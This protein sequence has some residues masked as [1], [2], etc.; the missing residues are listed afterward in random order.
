VDSGGRFY[1]DWAA[2]AP[3]FSCPPGTESPGHAALFGNPSSG[4]LEGRAARS[5]LEEARRVCA[6]ALGAEAGT[7][8]F[9]SGATEANAIVLF[10]LLCAQAGGVWQALITT[11]AEHPS[12]TNNCASLG[13]MGIPVHYMGV[14]GYGGAVPAALDKALHKH[15]GAT[16]L[17]L[18]YVNNETG[19]ISDLRG[20][21]ETAR[22]RD[23][24]ALHIHSDMAQALGKIP[25]TLSDM[26][27]DSAVFS[28]HK[29]GGPRGIGILYLRK[30]VQTLFKGGGQERGIRPG[31]E[32]TAGALYFAEALRRRTAA[33]AKDREEAVKKM[34]R[35]VE[36][37]RTVKRCTIIPECREAVDGR[38]SPYILQAAFKGVP[39]EVMTRALDD[40]GFAVSTGSACST[41]S[42]KRP[43]LNALG[44]D[45][46]V[47]FTSIRISFGWNTQTGDIDALVGA[48]RS[49]LS[50]L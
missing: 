8:Y 33:A 4:H 7:L 49:V 18:M 15:P 32:N 50:K 16:M 36:S 25:F 24:K 3:P 40:L 48:V 30:P 43:V 45:D 27:V 5:A 20:L 35:L 10:S 6:E 12:I 39:G 22:R 37:L 47:A 9:T 14:D 28:A 42:K 1:F 17:A 29:V 21:A 31:T 44:V 26:D 23:G 13:H 19:A 2:S 46:S 41:G 11:A 38:Y 34:A